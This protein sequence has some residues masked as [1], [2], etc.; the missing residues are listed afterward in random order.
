MVRKFNPDGMTVSP[1]YS[2]GVE[3]T[4]PARL[5]FV[6]GQVGALRDGSIAKGIEAQVQAVFANID[7]VLTGAGMT[8]ADVVKYTIFLV[9]GVDINAYRAAAGPL[10]P[11]PP[12]AS[13]L[14]FVQALASPDFLVEIEA[15]AMCQA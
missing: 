14:I 5:L 11:A 8:R 10:L 6:A 15:V 9:A 1:A 12:P 13:S 3:I 4:T 7:R 2:H